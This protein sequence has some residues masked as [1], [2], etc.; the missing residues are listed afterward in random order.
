MVPYAGCSVT[1]WGGWNPGVYP[2]QIVEQPSKWRRRAWCD[3]LTLPAAGAVLCDLHGI[4]WRVEAADDGTADLVVT[5]GLDFWRS[6]TAEQV[7][8]WEVLP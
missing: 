6:V 7:G 8:G 5:G 1:R 2:N 4:T 3:G